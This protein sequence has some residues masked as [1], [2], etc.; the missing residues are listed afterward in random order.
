MRGGGREKTRGVLNIASFCRW[1]D[2]GAIQCKSVENSVELS[3]GHAELIKSEHSGPVGRW[4]LRFGF[5]GRERGTESIKA[6]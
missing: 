2:G 3:F 4:K 5:Q 1:I 6:M